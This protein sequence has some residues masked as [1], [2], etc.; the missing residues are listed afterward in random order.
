MQ[1]SFISE[2][3]KSLFEVASKDIW[4]ILNRKIFRIDISKQIADF[5]S[6]DFDLDPGGF[7]CL[8]ERNKPLWIGAENGNT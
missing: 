5:D 6:S 8:S 2:E 3:V 7:L 4:A 1:S